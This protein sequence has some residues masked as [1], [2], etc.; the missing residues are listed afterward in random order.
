MQ[1]YLSV[2]RAAKLKLANSHTNHG[3]RKRAERW[4]RTASEA[5][6]PDAWDFDKVT[7][8]SSRL[9]RA[10]RKRKVAKIGSHVILPGALRVWDAG[11]A[12]DAYRPDE[13][14]VERL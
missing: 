10:I 12:L 3:S 7:A 6:G 11:M 13:H 4:I 8:F 1:L 14:V 9:N 5:G 2:P